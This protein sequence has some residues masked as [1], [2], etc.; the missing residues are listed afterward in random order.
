MG[1]F[2]DTITIYNHKADDTYQRTV[3]SGVQ[4]TAKA[5]K[6]ITSD[7]K[8]NLAAVVNVTITDTAVCDREY[9]PKRDFQKLE[10]TSG[11]WTLDAAGNQDIVIQGTVT[12]ELV[13]DYRLKHL[14]ADYDCV[15]VAA[16]ADNRNRGMMRHIKAVCK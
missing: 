14:K 3:I 10:D 11:Y 2:E 4:Y 7:G 16:V 5:V 13:R 6:T 8:V 15:T 1:L 12:Q 9:L